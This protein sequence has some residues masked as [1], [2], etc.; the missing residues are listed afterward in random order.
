MWAAIGDG[1]CPGNVHV[2]LPDTTAQ[3]CNRD[4]SIEAAGVT[5]PG[6]NAQ[7][8][9]C[10]T[11]QSFSDAENVLVEVTSLLGS[12]ACSSGVVNY[13]SMHTSMLQ[14]QWFSMVIII[15]IAIMAIGTTVAK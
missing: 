12:N 1:G 5:E 4:A 9:C 11:Q 13:E 10:G 15:I 7:K 2:L 8:Y 6:N 3:L 14:N